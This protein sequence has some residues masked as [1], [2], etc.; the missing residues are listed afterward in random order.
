M[1]SLAY[2]RRSNI[3]KARQ[4]DP[5]VSA[6][7]HNN[8]NRCYSISV[9]TSKSWKEFI[10]KIKKQFHLESNASIQI[11]QS[12]INPNNKQNEINL[13]EMHQYNTNHTDMTKIKHKYVF[14]IKL[15][16][17]DDDNNSTSDSSQSASTSN[18][19]NSS[20]END[21][22]ISEQKENKNK[23]TIN[24]ESQ[25]GLDMDIYGR[26][27]TSKKPPSSKK[28]SKAIYHY[29]SP[30][31]L[32]SLNFH[33]KETWLNLKTNTL[34]VK[35]IDNKYTIMQDANNVFSLRTRRMIWPRNLQFLENEFDYKLNDISS[36]WKWAIIIVHGGKFAGAIY[37]GTKMIFHKTLRRYVVR[38][39][40]GKRQLN[41]LSA[42]GVR[43]G[44]AGGYK[45][46][47]NEKK[48]L[49]E[50]REILSNWMDELIECDKIFIHTPGI[51]NQMTVYGNNE[52]Q[53]YLYPQFNGKLNEKL[54]KER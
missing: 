48:L 22:E 49:E 17:N 50:I 52:E 38:K 9:P 21:D 41:H 40:Q 39:K 42:S 12:S 19:S 10:I 23:S 54:S 4:R 30:H 53:N 18:S 3:R 45:R 5:I 14:C 8:P 35:H 36:K 34:K 27:C 7:M 51:H 15:N 26:F 32:Q 29:H 44:S 13:N 31:S 20:N 1:D 33:V 6:F 46:A 16:K 43:G 11:Y 25:F 28:N 24:D 47:W 37:H 2:Q